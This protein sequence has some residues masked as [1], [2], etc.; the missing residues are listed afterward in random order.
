[1]D[2]GG[3]GIVGM[4]CGEPVSGEPVNGELSRRFV[5][6]GRG[7]LEELLSLAAESV[8][9]IGVLERG[10]AEVPREEARGVGRRRSLGGV[11]VDGARAGRCILR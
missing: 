10:V 6:V 9:P 4:S 2:G 5:A 1:M 8:P 7:V 3:E 11:A